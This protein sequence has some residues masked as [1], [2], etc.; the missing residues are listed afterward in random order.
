MMKKNGFKFNKHKK[1]NK[2]PQKTKIQRQ[3]F[4]MSLVKII[5][6]IIALLINCQDMLALFHSVSK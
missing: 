5:V 1:E 2:K 6:K 3:V 4:S